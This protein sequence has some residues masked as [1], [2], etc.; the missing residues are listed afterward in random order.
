MLVRVESL[1]AGGLVHHPDRVI[2]R[3]VGDGPRI[4]KLPVGGARFGPDGLGRFGGGVAG[5]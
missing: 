4:G 2:R 5:N 3:G 1:H